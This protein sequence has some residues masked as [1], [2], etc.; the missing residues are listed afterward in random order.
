MAIWQ[1]SDAVA[2]VGSLP[3]APV[4]H[5][6]V[7]DPTDPEVTVL[8]PALNESATIE[9]FIAWCQEG[10]AAAG[11]NGEVV[12][13]DSSDDRTPELA[14]A[15]GARVLRVPRRG[16]GAAY[17]DARG[18]ARGSWVILGDVDCTY[19]FRDLRGFL[20]HLRQGDT[21]VMGNRF[22]GTI[23][24]GAMPIL[25]QY[26]GSPLTSGL[27][28]RALEVPVGDIHC[29]MR[30]MPTDFYNS[31]PFTESGWEYASEMIVVARRRKV[32]ISE[33]PIAFHIAP[34]GRLSHLQRGSPLIAWRAGIGTLRVTFTQAP[35]FLVR[36][37]SQV[38]FI[39]GG[40]GVVMLSGGPV[41]V[42]PF[43]FSLVV[44]AFSLA[45][46]LFG[47]GLF[48]LVALTREVLA[49]RVPLISVLVGSR[50]QGFLRG[51]VAGASGGLLLI[52]ICVNAWWRA[53]FTINPSQGWIGHLAITS[54]WLVGCCAF[55]GVLGLSLRLLVRLRQ[56][57]V[58]S[59]NRR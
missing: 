31:L 27:F 55:L 9:Q 49:E 54:F 8:V 33:V 18:V 51:L 57:P 44:Q 23:D 13:I 24:R 6:P 35:D 1:Y 20:N 4:L 36:G 53:G 16:L 2:V 19:D 32:A 41:S 43:R 25:H 59:L 28:A 26:F 39:L 47:L 7:N 22:T 37:L 42:G 12:I 45:V 10:F 17:R 38:L 21:F 14:L 11:V 58:L 29:G 34:R 15:A 5:L 30:A 48:G 40:L 46:S 50:W 56:D 52:G 3:E